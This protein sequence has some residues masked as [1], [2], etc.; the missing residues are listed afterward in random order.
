MVLPVQISQRAMKGAVLSPAFEPF[1]MGALVGFTELVV[2]AGMVAVTAVAIVVVVCERGGER[3][4]HRQR[5]GCQ[6]GFIH[7]HLLELMFDHCCK[8]T[9]ITDVSTA[10]VHLPQ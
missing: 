4:T 7:D 8:R 9:V 6:D 3:R 2:D 5:C 10:T 1:L